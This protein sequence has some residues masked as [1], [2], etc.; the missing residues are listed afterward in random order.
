MEGGHQMAE[1]NRVKDFVAARTE[2][3][4]RVA[5]MR[6][7]AVRGVAAVVVAWVVAIRAVGGRQ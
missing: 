6:A 3:R 1:A 5:A 2:G 7:V 4:A